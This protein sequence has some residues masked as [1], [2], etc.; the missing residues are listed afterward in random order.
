MGIANAVWV[1][2]GVNNAVVKRTGY[3]AR[4]VQGALALACAAVALSA[5][6]STGTKTSSTKT[7]V[8]TSPT[9]LYQTYERAAQ[10][11]TPA[12]DNELVQAF[13][14]KTGAC[15][16]SKGFVYYDLQG[17]SAGPPFVS[18]YQH[19]Y[20][21]LAD[22]EINGYGLYNY[23]VALEDQG[24]SHQ[25]MESSYIASLGPA[26][27]KKY[28][29][30]LLGAPGHEGRT[31]NIVGFGREKLA[32]GGCQGLAANEIYG[33]AVASWYLYSLTTLPA[34]ELHTLEKASSFQTSQQSW[35][36]C[37]TKD[38]YRFSSP[39]MAISSLESQ[40]A[41]DGPTAALHEKE[42]ATA[43]ADYHCAAATG[44]KSVYDAALRTS[45]TSLSPQD[46]ITVSAAS[47]DLDAALIQARHVLG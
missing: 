4:A 2:R 42:I 40:Y 31:F 33:S 23:Y 30:A 18:A 44:Y 36:A 47:R 43:V 3:A 19:P 25:D 22:R 37:M 34:D 24:S 39:S 1:T 28:M 41:V 20:S 7:V 11:D 12:A 15:M 16:R 38:G 21:S 26:K 17:A 14:D 10:S 35:S 32:T 9:A 8:P 6:G 45:V 29:N 13:L 46:K 5:C 27:Y